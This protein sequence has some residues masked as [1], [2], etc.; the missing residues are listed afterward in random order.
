MS[1]DTLTVL[2][3]D[4]S[5]SLLLSKVKTPDSANLE[6]DELE[7]QVSEL[8]TLLTSLKS[9]ARDRKLRYEKELKALEAKMEKDKTLSAESLKKELVE[10]QEEIESLLVEQQDELQ[11]AS[12]QQQQLTSESLVW[13]QMT[14]GLPDLAE[15]LE[16]SELQIQLTRAQ[17]EQEEL[18][19]LQETRT[20][21]TTIRQSGD[22]QSLKA[23]LDVEQQTLA[24]L[25]VTE[26]Q[27]RQ[28]HNNVLSDCVQC[29]KL[30]EQ[31]HENMIQ[32]LSTE[33]KK[34]EQ[35]FTSHLETVRRQ[36]EKERE[37][38]EN[39]VKS[40]KS[41][42]AD[43]QQIKKTISKRCLQQLQAAAN[44]IR[45]MDR[46][47]QEQRGIDKEDPTAT[48]LLIKS[49]G[50]ERENLV[51]TQKVERLE[52]EL[53]VLRNQAA[54]LTRAIQERRRPFPSFDLGFDAASLRDSFQ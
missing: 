31:I 24:E 49:E 17:S 33:N 3:D 46:L 14:A 15:D 4:L 53:D 25:G 40:A 27:Q 48:S 42:L 29:R 13:T 23:K 51:M 7:K 1:V 5:S 2:D 52:A 18:S 21:E 11:R 50:I 26:R 9:H 54:E 16:Q 34:R 45:Q 6:V 32:K 39:E 10:Q 22:L 28:Q 38:F 12:V 47:L 19:V 20:R 36:L 43:L 35:S 41:Q 37:R 44:D 30:L 8:S